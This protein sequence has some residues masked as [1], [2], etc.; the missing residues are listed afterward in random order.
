MRWCDVD[1]KSLC[2]YNTATGTAPDS[3]NQSSIRHNLE[4][5]TCPGHRRQHPRAEEMNPGKAEAARN[6]EASGKEATGSPTLKRGSRS[7]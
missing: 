1:A 6:K 2:N 3:A 4:N 5:P 7:P